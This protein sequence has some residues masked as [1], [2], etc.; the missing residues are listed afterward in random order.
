MPS[1]NWADCVVKRGIS[2][3]PTKVQKRSLQF[4]S[5]TS[6][7]SSSTI[8]QLRS[9]TPVS[10][11]IGKFSASTNTSS[12]GSTLSSRAVSPDS[13]C[14]DHKTPLVPIGPF[15]SGGDAHTFA[16]FETKRFCGEQSLEPESSFGEEELPLRVKSRF[17]TN[18]YSS[19]KRRASSLDSDSLSSCSS[20]SNESLPLPS[21]NQNISPVNPDFSPWSSQ[22]SAPDTI[23]SQDSSES[24]PKIKK[25]FV[26]QEALTK[27]VESNSKLQISKVKKCKTETNQSLSEEKSCNYSSETDIHY[28]ENN[29]TDFQSPEK[30]E[31]NIQPESCL[32]SEHI[33]AIN[34][35]IANNQPIVIKPLFDLNT[36]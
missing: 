7:R 34:A 21:P 33:A 24:K 9:D 31:L 26:T 28:P 2:E 19:N 32:N 15:L 27:I 22:E 1:N 12:S 18:H 30:L 36:L 10:E 35:A 8:K 23:A 11:V 5:S 6:V 13:D 25:V 20:R 17:S 29:T 3:I 16:S 14:V 4:L